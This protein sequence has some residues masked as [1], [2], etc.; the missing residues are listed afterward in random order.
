MQNSYITS[1]DYP[2]PDVIRVDDTYYM[3]TTSMYFMPGC[4]IL[5]SYD[6]VNWEHAAYVYE[7]L[8]DTSAQKLEGV[9]NIYGKGMWA[10][11]FRY[12]KN[13][14]Y[15]C[16]VANDTQKTYLYTS[17]KIEG[18]WKKSTIKGF[19]HDCSLLFDDEKVYIVY[20]NREIF[21][22]ELKADLSGPKE[23]GVHK[24][25][26]YDKYPGPLGYEGCHIYKIGGK[27]VLLT[28]H[29]PLVNAGRKVQSC[30]ISDSLDGEF[31]GGIVVSDDRGFKNLGVAQGCLVDTPEGD[32]YSMLFQ[33]MGAIGRIPV[34][35][36]VSWD[37]GIPIFG[38]YGDVPCEMGGTGAKPNYSY[39][40][41]YGGDDFR[42]IPDSDGK[43]HLKEYWQ[44]N[45]NP[46]N[47]LWSVTERPGALRIYTAK[48]SQN[49][50]QAVNTLTQ[51]M[52]FPRC[53]ATVTIDAA[54]LNDGDY[55]CF[56]AF[57]ACYG[58][59][60]LH[61]KN[62]KLYLE[63]LVKEAKDTSFFGEENDTLP[64]KQKTSTE[65]ENPVI[66][67]K[68]D[69]VFGEDEYV[70]FSHYKNGIWAQVGFP[71]KIYFKM[72][73]FTGCRFA[74]SVFSTEKTGGYADFLN[75]QYN[76]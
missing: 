48:L 35:M 43:I 38:R 71:H 29:M 12:H 18:P 56:S 8:D 33:D 63:T 3:V 70:T 1:T 5:R 55:A 28:C 61:R 30:F 49:V 20:G 64:G 72:D 4:E 42:Y 7:T 76:C 57:Q 17:D 27:Y 65:I 58:F 68:I 6:L 69:A 32:W 75:F 19:Y 9:Q 41:L 73:H 15:I 67:L 40:P 2:D 66:R 23:N 37:N 39:A 13:T 74:L 34:L 45:H 10:A 25:I 62:G 59:I 46:D 21:L 31:Y 24:R 14:F 22:T 50:T 44:W 54:G 47:R 11:S 26:L 52:L 16:F 60:G 36:P 53:S 51:R